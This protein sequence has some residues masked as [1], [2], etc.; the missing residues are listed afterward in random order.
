[1][2]TIFH[3]QS[4]HSVTW[5]L[6]TRVLHFDQ[7]KKPSCCKKPTTMGPSNHPCDEYQQHCP[8]VFNQIDVSSSLIGGINAA[9]HLAC[10][11]PRNARL[12]CCLLPR[13]NNGACST[14]AL[15]FLLHSM[16]APISNT[17]TH[18]V[19]LLSFQQRSSRSVFSSDRHDRLSLCSRQRSSHD[20]ISRCQQQLSTTIALRAPQSSAIMQQRSS[21][22]NII[23]LCSV[24]INSVCRNDNRHIDDGTV[25]VNKTQQPLQRRRQQQPSQQ[26]TTTLLFIPTTLAFK[27]HAARQLR[28]P[29][30]FNSHAAR[31]LCSTAM[32]DNS[33]RQFRA[34]RFLLVRSHPM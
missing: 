8:A 22:T 26:H 15:L 31:Q 18:I 11:L 19:F 9:G 3:C 7:N 33:V 17:Y 23:L 14:A 10:S 21:R 6:T 12:P 13:N 16:C 30:L 5:S 4:F 28:S 2:L 34:G 1:M 29:V 32:L 20:R 25:I 27:S 24:T